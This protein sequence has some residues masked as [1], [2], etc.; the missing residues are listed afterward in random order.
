MWRVAP[1]LLPQRLLIGLLLFG[2]CLGLGF[3]AGPAP[4][5]GVTLDIRCLLVFVHELEQVPFF[6]LPD[7]SDG[8]PVA[9]QSSMGLHRDPCRVASD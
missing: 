4:G 6:V 3:G 7:F 2:G 5:L 8:H 9:P 1:R